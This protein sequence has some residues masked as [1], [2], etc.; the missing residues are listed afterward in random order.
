MH[1]HEVLAKSPLAHETVTR[2]LHFFHDHDLPFLLHTEAQTFTTRAIP[3]RLKPI[4]QAYNFEPAETV[5]AE[6][7]LQSTLDVYQ[8]NVFMTAD[9]E[10]RVH[11]TFP[12]CL[13]YRWDAEAVDLQR[14]S[15]DKS[16]G[17][18]ALLNYLGIAPDRAVHFGDGGNDIGMFQ[19]MGTSVAMGNAE[20]HVKKHA[21]FQT[22]AVDDDGVLLGLQRLGLF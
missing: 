10:A 15:S 6:H 14:R 21:Q 5:P 8:A 9:W 20:P 22:T 3:R 4:L 2:A 16:I 1:D 12:E 7:L 11:Q 17:A 13:I 19:T 18:M